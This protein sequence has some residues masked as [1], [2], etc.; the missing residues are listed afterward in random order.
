M[1][2][3]TSLKAHRT[4]SSLRVKK[5]GGRQQ[6]RASD[7]TK[8]EDQETVRGIVSLRTGRLN[9]RLHAVTDAKGRPLTIF[10]TAGQVS[11]CTGAAALLGSLP[12]AEWL[13]ADRGGDADR[14]REALKGKGIKPCIAG[15][16][17]RGTAVR[18]DKRRYKRR[19]RIEIMSGR[20]KDWRRIATG[21]DRCPTVLLS[22]VALSATV[23]FWL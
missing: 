4:A 22:A 2:D 18:D 8:F 17:S 12:G 21:Y 9:T 5:G 16:K 14:F 13:I 20:L 19:N 10:V 15:R 23:M 11:N 7:R 3:A 6:A 1:I